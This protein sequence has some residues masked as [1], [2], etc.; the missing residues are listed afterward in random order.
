[1]KILNFLQKEAIITNLS[2]R[3]KKETLEELAAPVAKILKIDNEILVR[4]LMERE[5]L[6][7]TGYDNGVGLPHAKLKNIDDTVL[8]FGVSKKGIDFDSL[9][10]GP[11][12]IFF[13]LLTSENSAGIHL[14]LL[15][16]ISKILKNENFRKK[17]MKAETGA[18]IL[19]IIKKADEKYSE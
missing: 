9:D 7:S 12:N 5:Q 18:E 1:M 2:A 15:A 6:G 16:K 17:V 3:N 13:L 8:S 14:R 11:T 4:A 10:G 19:S